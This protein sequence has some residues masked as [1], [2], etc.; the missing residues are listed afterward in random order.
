MIGIL[1]QNPTE[2]RLRLGAFLPPHA[3]RRFLENP[4]IGIGV[5]ELLEGASRGG[6]IPE[7]YQKI[8]EQPPALMQL[9]ILLER[10]AQQ[11]GGRLQT[12]LGPVGLRQIQHRI[13]KV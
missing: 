3:L 9:A 2:Y 7:I 12:A 13:G 11:L 4:A 1:M 10:L 8:T 5:D 6:E